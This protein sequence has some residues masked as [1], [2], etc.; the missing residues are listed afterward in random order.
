[1]RR[2]SGIRQWV[3]QGDRDLFFVGQRTVVPVA[4]EIAHAPGPLSTRSQSPTTVRCLACGSIGTSRRRA[5][6]ARPPS[7]EPSSSVE[8]LGRRQVRDGR[9]EVHVAE[10]LREHPRRHVREEHRGSGGRPRS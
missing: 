7:W 5:S 9:E 2:Y 3:R 1:M 10:D 6:R 8:E 4:S